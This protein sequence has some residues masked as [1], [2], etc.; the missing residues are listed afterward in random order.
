MMIINDYRLSMLSTSSL[1][2]LL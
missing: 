2:K 1:T